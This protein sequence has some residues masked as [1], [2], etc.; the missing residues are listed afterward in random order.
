MIVDSSDPAAQFRERLE[1][2]EQKLEA[3]EKEKQGR[4]EMAQELRAENAELRRAR[5]ET[6]QQLDAAMEEK[7]GRLKVAE[8]LRAENVEL[9]RALKET[10]DRLAVDEEDPD[11]LILYAQ[12]LKREAKEGTKGRFTVTMKNGR[13]VV[14]QNFSQQ[15]SLCG[16]GYNKDATVSQRQEKRRVDAVA[17]I[18][19]G[20]FGGI[21]E[22][23]VVIG[24]KLK[25]EFREA[26]FKVTHSGR[27]EKMTAEE[28]AEMMSFLG[29]SYNQMRRCRQ[30]FLVRI[31]LEHESQL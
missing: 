5:K 3:L 7:Q 15:R 22:A 1:C 13:N 30:F 16:G 17:G 2:V 19:T 6:E 27:L 10:E 14:Y 25:K 28:T 18:M 9:R 20:V 24:N 26:T 4:L 21:T 31:L 8:E 11:G 29:L 23:L 12:V